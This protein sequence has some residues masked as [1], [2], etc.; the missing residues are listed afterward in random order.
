MKNLWTSLFLL[1][2][3]N[4]LD[5]SQNSYEDAHLKLAQYLKQDIDEKQRVKDARTAALVGAA[6]RLKK[7]MKRSELKSV[8]NDLSSALLQNQANESILSKMSA[9]T[10]NHK[11]QFPLC[12]KPLVWQSTIDREAEE[13]RG[14]IDETLRREN[15]TVYDQLKMQSNKAV[16]LSANC[17]IA[18]PVPLELGLQQRLLVQHGQNKE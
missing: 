10:E 2:C 16:D 6:S 7:G 14:R 13:L 12:C 3:C 1:L 18:Y 17:V 8:R 15:S 4:A 9:I 5:A 11:R